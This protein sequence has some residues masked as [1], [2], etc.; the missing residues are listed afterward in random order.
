MNITMDKIEK[1]EGLSR[2]INHQ[3]RLKR[4]EILVE[5][6]PQELINLNISVEGNRKCIGY[7]NL[8]ELS[9]KQMLDMLNSLLATNEKIINEL[10]PVNGAHF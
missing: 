10:K 9:T 4:L 2:A 5:N 1:L 6:N 7:A 8:K 3:A